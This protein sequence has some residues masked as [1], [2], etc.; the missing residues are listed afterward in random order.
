MADEVVAEFE[1]VEKAAEQKLKEEI[2]KDFAETDEKDLT[3][4]RAAKVLE[5]VVAIGKA[6]Q[7]MPEKF[8]NVFATGMEQISPL[9]FGRIAADLLGGGRQGMDFI[10]KIMAYRMLLKGEGEKNEDKSDPLLEK[11]IDLLKEQFTTT[12]E[13][14]EQL[15]KEKFV[16]EITE[17]LNESL[18]NFNE[19]VNEIEKEISALKARTESKEET[20]QKEPVSPLKQMTQSLSEVEEFIKTLEKLGLVKRPE[21]KSSRSISDDIIIK[22]L[23]SKGYIVKKQPT[24]DDIRKMIKKMEKK[25]RKEVER[26]LKEKY[27]AEDKK[28]LLLFTA[29]ENIVTPLAE[30][31]REKLTGSAKSSTPNPNPSTTNTSAENEPPKPSLAQLVR[32]ERLRRMQQQQGGDATNA[33]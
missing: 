33:S 23:E 20:E 11:L 2:R 24:W 14:L 16:G 7:E 1:D 30:V 17:M 28:A 4:E 31:A 10:D 12:K 27:E 15:E 26:E 18:K 22:E 6:A 5:P 8:Q 21:E 32:Q 19:R 13:K 3:L 29:I 9:L 25:I